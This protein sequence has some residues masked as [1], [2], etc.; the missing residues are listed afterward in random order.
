MLL[1][2]AP[3]DE[4]SVGH[5]GEMP[6]LQRHVEPLQRREGVQLHLRRVHRVDLGRE[7]LDGDAA[8]AHA[9]DVLGR[10]E[11]RVADGYAVDQGRAVL[12]RREAEAR[13][14]AEAEA[15]GADPPEEPPL[16]Q[17]PRARQVVLEFVVEVSMDGT[18]L[19]ICEL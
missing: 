12:C 5:P 19:C 6:V 16:V 3:P 9:V 7:H 10:Q 17:R 1:T 15:G 18:D 4:T 13:P 14:A 11:R 2:V 8:A